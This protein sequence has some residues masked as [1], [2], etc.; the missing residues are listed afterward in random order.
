VIKFPRIFQSVF[1]LLQH[2]RE[3]ICWLHTNKLQWLKAKELITPGFLMELHMYRC[4][5]V[6][7]GIYTRYQTINFVE[8]NI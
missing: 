5:G 4:L 3:E 2:S 8:K 7:E 6:K 1:Y